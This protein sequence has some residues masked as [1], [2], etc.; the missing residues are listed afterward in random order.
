MADKYMEISL[1]RLG[2]DPRDYDG[3]F[4]GIKPG[5]A[6]VSG[7]HADADPF[8]SETTLPTTTQ[9]GQPE[10]PEFGRWNIY[11]S[12]PPAHWHWQGETSNG[13]AVVGEGGE[14]YEESARDPS[15]EI[16]FVPV[17]KFK[18]EKEKSRG[19][20]GSDGFD[21]ADVIMPGKDERGWTFAFDKEGIYQIY[22]Q[23]STF[24]PWLGYYFVC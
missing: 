12:P 18:E 7:I 13:S 15:G 1:Q 8:S 23:P 4:A 21:M 17:D 3:N 16:K 6:D 20:N 9:N 10:K 24:S 11:P 5:H 19:T 22:D 14:G 2:D